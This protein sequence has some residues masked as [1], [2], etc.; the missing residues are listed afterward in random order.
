MPARPI[1]ATLA[2]VLP[3]GSGLKNCTD[4]LGGRISITGRFVPHRSMVRPIF[5]IVLDIRVKKCPL[6]V[7]VQ[8]S[9]Q[10]RL[11]A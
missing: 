3:G 6:A 11:Q 5:S 2:G 4:Q 9:L 8:Q 10:S 1:G 7:F